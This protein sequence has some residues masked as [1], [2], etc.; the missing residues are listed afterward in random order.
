MLTDKQA[1][2]NI[3]ANVR[4]LRAGRSKYWLAKALDVHPIYITRLENA[5]NMPGAGLLARLAE[6][7]GTTTDA[8]L[9]MDARNLSHAS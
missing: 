3:A 5:E 7:L 6:A 2:A 1:L 9:S 4:R 8:L